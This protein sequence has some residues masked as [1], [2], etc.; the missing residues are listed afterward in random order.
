MSSDL[1]DLIYHRAVNCGTR[2]HQT[3]ATSLF[4]SG[5]QAVRNVVCNYVLPF[6]SLCFSAWITSI[7]VPSQRSDLFEWRLLAWQSRFIIKRNASYHI[8][9]AEPRK[10]LANCRFNHC[11]S[12]S[13]L[14]QMMGTVFKWRAH[15]LMHQFKV[16]QMPLIRPLPHNL[17]QGNP[18]L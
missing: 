15:H 7:W 16:S 12:S 1:T 14:R 4:S 8:A 13:F 18:L 2:S 9:V 6:C 5:L 10:S 11:S 17:L 3:R